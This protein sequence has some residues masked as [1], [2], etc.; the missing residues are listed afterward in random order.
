MT[1]LNKVS[2]RLVQASLFS[3]AIALSVSVPAAEA[4]T[5]VRNYVGGDPGDVAGGG[6][7]E[8]V[9]N[10]AADLWEEAILNDHTLTINYGWAPRSGNTLANIS[11]SQSSTAPVRVT[12]GTTFF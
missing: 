5:I 11:L 4:L 1:T 8:T 7:L 6:D 9:F 3:T 12:S 2:R 10:A